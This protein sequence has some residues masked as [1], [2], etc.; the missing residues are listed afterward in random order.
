[1]IG[2]DVAL[3][4]IILD[5]A[6]DRRGSEGPKHAIC[7]PRTQDPGP[8]PDVFLSASPDDVFLNVFL[9]NP[10]RSGADPEEW[11]YPRKGG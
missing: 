9:N 10:G 4:T 5:V 11:A 6:R 8:G 1:M 7:A 3:L 2:L